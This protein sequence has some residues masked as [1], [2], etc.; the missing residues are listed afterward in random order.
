[1]G[2]TVLFGVIETGYVRST[3]TVLARSVQNFDAAILAS[4]RVGE[5]SGTVW[6]VVIHDQKFC[7]GCVGEEIP[8][9]FS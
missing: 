1:V 6:A 4:Q 3:Q 5:V 9:S 7:L 8:H 2:E